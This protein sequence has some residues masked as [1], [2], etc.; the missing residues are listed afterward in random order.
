MSASLPAS[1]TILPLGSVADLQLGKMLD[2]AR[3]IAGDAHQYLRNVNVRWGTF[4]LSDLAEMR[5]TSDEAL[6][7]AV[8]DGD[9][10]VCEGGEPGRAAVWRGGS[11]RL[12]FQKALHRVRPSSVLL[13]DWV[14]YYLSHIAQ[15]GEIERH[16]TGT[17]IKHL[18]SQALAAVDLPLP[19]LA[20]QRR[21]VARIEAL[22]ARIR[23]ARADLVRIAPLARHFRDRTLVQAFDAGWPEASIADLAET[24]FDG[25]FGSNL[26]SSDY[27]ATGTRVVRLENIGHLYFIDEK[28]TFVPAAKGYALARHTLH[29]DDVL[30]SSFVDKEVRVCRLP[31]HLGGAAINK[32]DCFCVRVDRRKALPEFVEKRLASPVT[33]EGMRE[34]VHGATRPRI[35]LSD[36]KTYRVGLPSIEIQTK[37]VAAIEVAHSASRILERE[38]C[39]ALALLDHLERRILTRAFCGELVPQDPADASALVPFKQNGPAADPGRSEAGTKPRGRRPNPKATNNESK[40]SGMGKARADVTP[41]HLRATLKALGGKAKARDLWRQSGMDLDEFYKLLRDD[42]KAGYVLE[43]K[44]KDDLVLAHAA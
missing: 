35:G 34:A 1:W 8:A 16:F 7:F 6:R 39:R 10:L 27:T 36:L 14:A 17:T 29:A 38:A 44:D 2:R 42:V 33:Y 28:E 32:A 13:S 11:T 23:Q 12:K 26:K 41:E 21:I 3:N 9:V 43:G 18:P 5:F 15:T 4:D 19:P 37:T 30:F 31:K 40:E 25:P 24:T 22:F 20:E